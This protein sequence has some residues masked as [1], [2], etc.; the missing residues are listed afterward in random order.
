MMTLN[1]KN[2]ETD[3]T[4]TDDTVNH[5]WTIPSRLTQNDLVGD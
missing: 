3:I 2:A 4:Y 1:N 5:T